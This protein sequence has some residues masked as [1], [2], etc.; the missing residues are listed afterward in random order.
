MGY[1]CMCGALESR[2]R[3]VGFVACCCDGGVET[4]WIWT[5]MGKRVGILANITIRILG[6]AQ[7]E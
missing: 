7:T 1:G 2:R 5:V 4:A 3:V 6:T